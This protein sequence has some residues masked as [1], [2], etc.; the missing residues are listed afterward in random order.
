MI[1]ILESIIL[2]SQLKNISPD[3]NLIS[4]TISAY[5]KE[6]LREISHELLKEARDNNYATYEVKK[7][8]VIA[9]IS[10]QKASA[11]TALAKSWQE[12]DAELK[13]LENKKRELNELKNK[14][15]TTESELKQK[16]KDR[17]VDVFDESEQTM[18]LVVEC[19][20]S[21]FTLSKKTEAN[22]DKVVTPKGEII[23][24]DY[25]KVVELLLEQNEDLK[26]T[27]DDLIKNLLYWLQKM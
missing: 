7:D 11:F 18:T 5:S 2:N 22:Q 1:D 27:I 10:A 13:I 20:N 19:L 25:K 12:M 16:I 24:T 8:R 6:E 9:K 3:L 15:D 23:S 21:A 17:I 26:G 4:E 14:V